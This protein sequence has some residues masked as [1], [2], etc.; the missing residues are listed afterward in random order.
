MPPSSR[1]FGTGIGFALAGWKTFPGQVITSWSKSE[2][3]KSSLRETAKITPAF[4][5]I[6]AGIAVPPIEKNPAAIFT[7]A[8]SSV[9]ITPGLIRCM[10][11]WLPRRVDWIQMISKRRIIRFTTSILTLGAASF[12]STWRRRRCNHS[13]RF[14]VRK[15]KIWTAG[16]LPTWSLC[17]RSIVCVNF[18]SGCEVAC[19][20]LLVACAVI[21]R[22]FVVGESRT[23][24]PLQPEATGATVEATKRLK[25]PVKGV[26]NR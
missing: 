23:R 9:P 15:P 13:G 2:H 20:C 3:S 7:M 14:S 4:F 12:L 17:I 10:E 18:I 1:L 24:Q 16:R 5:I 6:L 25:P 21:R 8:A 26:T 19:E 11:I 22:R